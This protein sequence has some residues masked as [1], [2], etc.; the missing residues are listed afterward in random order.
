QTLN[1]ISTLSSSMVYV[2]GCYYSD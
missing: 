1:S 2:V